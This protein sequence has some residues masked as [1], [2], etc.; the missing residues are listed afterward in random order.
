MAELTKLTGD[1]PLVRCGSKKS[2]LGWGTATPESMA[3]A[4]CAVLVQCVGVLT[5]ASARDMSPW[6]WSAWLSIL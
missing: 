2:R 5:A 6:S 4:G 3:E 1:A